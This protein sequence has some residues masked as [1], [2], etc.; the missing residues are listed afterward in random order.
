MEANSPR[1]EMYCQSKTV[2]CNVM[3]I[4]VPSLQGLI[5]CVGGKILAGIFRR[6][7][8]DLR[9]TRSGLPDLVV[10]NPTS[11]IYKVTLLSRT[12]P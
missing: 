4:T 3:I 10:W 6:L 12:D 7:A 8:Q 9:H 1:C 5:K 2:T 11:T